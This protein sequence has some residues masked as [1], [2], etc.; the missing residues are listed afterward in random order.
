MTF[1]IKKGLD[2]PIT[3]SPVQ[4]IQQGPAVK[5]VAIIGDDYVGMRPTM[6][7]QEG[8]TVKLGQ[9]LFN[10]KKREGVVFTSPGAGKVV[11]ITRG[12]KRKF[13][14]VEVELAGDDEITFGAT[15]IWE[16]WIVRRLKSNSS[17]L[18]HG[19]PFGLDL[20][21]ARP[22]SAVSLARSL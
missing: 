21:V 15:T 9:P 14:S 16:H 3:G 1:T 6:L 8:D 13:E 11:G 5:K 18:E 4:D 22:N 19:S 10:D 20:S 2:L 12:A 7:V 17:I